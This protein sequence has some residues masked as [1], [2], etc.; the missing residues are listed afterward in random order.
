MPGKNIPKYGYNFLRT[1][2]KT[3]FDL[4]TI[5]VDLRRKVAKYVMNERYVP[6]K[7]RYFD[8]LPAVD[9]ARTIRDDISLANDIKIGTK[10]ADPEKVKERLNLQEHALSYCNLLQDQ[11]LDIIEDC[12][13]ATETSMREI[14]DMLEDL[15]K[16]LMKW[17]DTDNARSGLK[18]GRSL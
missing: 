1:R 15:I 10:D 18:P 3:Q 13:P 5:A 16:R 14:S 7:W 17:H 8:G 2:R 6:K 4:L 11:L 9:Y 12:E